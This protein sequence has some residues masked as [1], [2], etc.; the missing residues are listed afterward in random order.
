MRRKVRTGNTAMRRSA[1]IALM[2]GLALAPSVLMAGGGEDDATGDFA[3]QGPSYYGFVFDHRGATVPG[4][5]VTLRGKSGKA[6]EQKTNLMGMYRTHISKDV[7]A[8]EVV[9][10]CAKDGFKQVRIVRRNVPDATTSRVQ[11]D[12]VLQKGG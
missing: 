2:T 12:C 10:T 9:M 7:K 3:T 11:I 1:A 4:A 8:S 6:A 5:Q